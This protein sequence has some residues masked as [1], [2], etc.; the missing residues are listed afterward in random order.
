MYSIERIKEINNSQRLQVELPGFGKLKNPIMIAS[1]CANFGKE[2]VDYIEIDE[3]GA[4]ALKS[5][6]S[7][8]RFGNSMPRVAEVENGMLN[9]IG[10]ANPGMD[11]LNE[12]FEYLS[13]KKCNVIANVAGS[14]E[15]EYLEVINKLNSYEQID[16]YEINVSCPNVKKGCMQIGTNPEI[17][18]ELI[19]KIKDIAIKPVYVK[20]TPNTDD[21]VKQAKAVERAGADGITM[22]NTLS[23]MAIDYR[24]GKPILA[25]ITGGYSGPSLKPIALKM[26]YDV[27][28]NTSLPIIGMG[29]ISNEKDVV[30]FMEVGASAVMVGTANLINPLITM[31]IIERLPEVLDK[32]NVQKIKDLI[33]ITHN[34]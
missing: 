30:E 34:Y 28:K 16:V 2:F 29:G 6:T 25:N 1:G 18:E 4:I 21:I 9:A 10:L 23:A 31:E 26:V 3:L 22:I 27:A 15:E 7:E 11:N 14:T 17:L 13:N 20:L 33:G 12:E 32:I 8:K 5:I 24:T 19:R